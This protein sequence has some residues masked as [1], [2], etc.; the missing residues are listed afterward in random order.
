MQ[1]KYEALSYNFAFTQFSR[2]SVYPSI[3]LLLIFVYFERETGTETEHEQGRGR[4]WETQNPKA[5]SRLQAV[6][7]EPDV[8]LEPTNGEI[9]T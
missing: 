8:G 5:G 4:E 2:P 6:S 1:G 9:M 7:T 3:Y